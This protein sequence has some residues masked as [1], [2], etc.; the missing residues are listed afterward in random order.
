MMDRSIP[1][2]F[3]TFNAQAIAKMA[4][5]ELGAGDMAAVVFT[6]GG[7]SFQG[8]RPIATSWSRRLTPQARRASCPRPPMKCGPNCSTAWPIR[9][10][11]C[12]AL[13]A[14]DFGTD[15]M[16]GTCV[17][18]ASRVSRTRPR[19]SADAGASTLLFIGRDIQVETV[20]SICI[21]A[22]RKARSQMFTSLDLASLGALDRS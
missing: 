9:H 10:S 12:S 5:N 22:V 15:C 3:P 2:G 16:C 14:L 1:D 6:S 18:R 21:D 13:G 19:R 11:R 20:D 17:L 8:S 7:G 4:V